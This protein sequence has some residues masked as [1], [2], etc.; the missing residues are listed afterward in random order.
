VYAQNQ[1]MPGTTP[2]GVVIVHSPVN[3]QKFI[4]SP[5][6]LILPNG[7]Y[8]ASHDLFG[9]GEKRAQ[10]FI[11]ESTDRGESWKLVSEINDQYW[12]NLFY[13]KG[14]V[15]LMGTTKEY[16]F[17]V[18]RRST[19]NGKTWTTPTNNTNGIL[20]ND[21]EY[22][23]APVP[24]VIYKGRIWRSMEDRNPPTDWGIYFRTFVMSAPIN[25][26]LL[27][28]KNWESTNRLSYDQEWP[29]SAWLE[30]NVVVS[31][32]GYLW[33]I[34]R[35]HTSQGEKAAIVKVGLTGKVVTFDPENDFINF[36]GGSVKFTIRFDSVSNKYYSLT[37]YIPPNYKGNNPERTRNTLA[38]ISS[39]DLIHWKVNHIVWQDV[40]V[41]NV[42]FQYVDFRFDRKDIVFVSRTAYFEKNGFGTQQHDSN[43]LTFYR[44]K[45]FR[46]Y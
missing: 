5:S 1:N 33:N 35:N 45:N 40:S 14:N 12:S 20:L 29:G 32:H 7:N 6:L 23:T 4:G 34:L 16:G 43:Y 44:I 22:H 25:S 19:D 8:L 10:T 42:G 30:G 28:A 3:S 9:P 18:I 36:P 13:L 17:V 24:V 11:Y 27:E 39:S 37:N 46:S 26:D 15:Y 2:P 38:L 21:G 31:P 41:S